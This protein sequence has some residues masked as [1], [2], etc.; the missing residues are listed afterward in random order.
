MSFP[1]SFFTTLTTMAKSHEKKYDTGWRDGSATWLATLYLLL[2]LGLHR[3]GTNALPSL[4]SH[5]KND[6]EAG[7]TQQGPELELWYCMRHGMR[8]NASQHW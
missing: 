5:F 1:I 6:E 7:N 8:G 3:G 2:E 4:D